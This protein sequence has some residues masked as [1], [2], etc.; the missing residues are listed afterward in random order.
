MDRNHKL[1]APDN[2]ALSSI[3]QVGDHSNLS[4]LYRKAKND[5]T[6]ELVSEGERERRRQTKYDTISFGIRKEFF[7]VGFL[8]ALPVALMSVM[9]AV[10]LSIVTEANVGIMV[11]PTMFAFLFWVMAAYFTYRAVY[12][13]F[14]SNALQATPFIIIL[15]MYLGLLAT[16]LHIATAGIHAQNPLTATLVI[17]GIELILS[18]VIALP[19]LIIWTTPKLSANAKLMII[20]TPIAV[21]IGVNLFLLFT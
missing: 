6:G 12:R 11:I 20:C 13:M 4:T 7:G 16:I 21:L 1:D 5:W 17:T 8:I 19:L 14:Y 10:I 9:V 3:D 15:L 2:E 18:M